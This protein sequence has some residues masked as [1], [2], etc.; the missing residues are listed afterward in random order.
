MRSGVG[1]ELWSLIRKQESP[2]RFSILFAPTCLR[3]NAFK[4]P[5][6]S[7]C[8]EPI[9]VEERVSCKKKHAS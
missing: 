7:T 3:G 9:I 8:N 6:C 1:S 4:M 2:I 5:L